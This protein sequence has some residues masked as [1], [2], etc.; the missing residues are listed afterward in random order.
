[1]NQQH[2]TY[3]LDTC[4][5]CVES[6]VQRYDYSLCSGVLCSLATQDEAQMNGKVG[7]LSLS[8]S[9]VSFITLRF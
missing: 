1:M 8:M 7:V 6:H 5:Q 4:K 9:S 2:Y 3:E